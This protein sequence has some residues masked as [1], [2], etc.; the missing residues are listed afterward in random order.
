M[1]DDR[2][3]RR[4]SGSAAAAIG[5]FP[6]AEP[7]LFFHSPRDVVV[8]RRRGVD[9]R[10]SWALSQGRKDLAIAVA[11]DRRQELRYCQH[12]DAQNYLQTYVY[13]YRRAIRCSSGSR[14]RD[15]MENYFMKRDNEMLTI[16]A[17]RLDSHSNT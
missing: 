17:L 11:V 16:F 5:V 14:I 12:D 13:A 7:V 15:L 10:V 1:A 2:R 8:G 6:A 4:F 9:D 3:E